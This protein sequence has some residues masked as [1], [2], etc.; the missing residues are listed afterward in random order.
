MAFIPHVCSHTLEM[1]TTDSKSRTLFLPLE[2]KIT[3]RSICPI[4]LLRYL[5]MELDNINGH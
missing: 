3:L 4:V 1:L 5:L 2:F